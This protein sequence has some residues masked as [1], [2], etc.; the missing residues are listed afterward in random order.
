MNALGQFIT[1]F[2]MMPH[3]LMLVN[4]HAADITSPGE[5]ESHLYF[6]LAYMPQR[7]QWYFR[8][9]ISNYVYLGF[10]TI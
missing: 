1:T 3:R 5:I 7:N 4:C 10:Y 9:D 8:F 6:V 2:F